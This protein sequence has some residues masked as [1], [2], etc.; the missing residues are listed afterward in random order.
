LDYDYVF[1]LTNNNELHWVLFIIVPAE[2][3]VECYDS[4][5]EA[6]GFHYESLSVIIRFLKDYQVLNNLPVDDRTWSVKI[7]SEPKENN[8]IDCLHANVLHDERLGSG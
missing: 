2:R 1:I 3:R 7:V 8:I 6:G 4:L 5:Y